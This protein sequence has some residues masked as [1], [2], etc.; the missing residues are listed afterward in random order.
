MSWTVSTTSHT[1]DMRRNSSGSLKVWFEMLKITKTIA[2]ED[3]AHEVKYL[4]RV[5]L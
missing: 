3:H 1:W 4:D 2:D 5:N